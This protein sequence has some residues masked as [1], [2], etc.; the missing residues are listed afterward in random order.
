[1]F[2]D[3]PL[4][5]EFANFSN[6]CGHNCLLVCRLGEKLFVFARFDEYIA[7]IQSFNLSRDTFFCYSPLLFFLS[8][9]LYV[10]V[11]FERS[12]KMAGMIV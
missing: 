8:Y 1:M 10:P 12:S 5:C 6:E 3:L 2:R 11:N 4:R 9:L 7:P